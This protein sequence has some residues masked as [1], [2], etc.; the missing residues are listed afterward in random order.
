[1]IVPTKIQS[2]LRARQGL[3]SAIIVVCI[4]PGLLLFGT[5]MFEENVGPLGVWHGTGASSFLESRMAVTCFSFLVAA[6]PYLT[7]AALLVGISLLLGGATSR[8]WSLA[9]VILLVAACVGTAHVSGTAHSC[10]GTTPFRVL[11]SVW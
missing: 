9:L 3:L 4:A 6:S 10:W 7:T 5:L 1:M 8:A 2:C 11:R